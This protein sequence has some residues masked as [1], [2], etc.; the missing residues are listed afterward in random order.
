MTS[1]RT[2]LG[3]LTLAGL[4]LLAVAPSRAEDAPG[5]SWPEPGGR[6]SISRPFQ[7]SPITLGLSSRTGGAID[8]LTWGGT[9][10]INAH[11]HGRELQSA[12]SFD[13]FWCGS[14]DMTSDR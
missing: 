5:L 12:A 1:T 6:A 10:F 13:G 3:T 11:D 8:S 4:L 9:Q 7:G 2:L 14:S